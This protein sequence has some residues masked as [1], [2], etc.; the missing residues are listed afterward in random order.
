VIGTGI[1]ATTRPA[2]AGALDAPP[3]RP[4]AAIA[5]I[6]PTVRI[7]ATNHPTDSFRLG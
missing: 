2:G 7:A 5:A 6:T 4:P 3:P 1:G